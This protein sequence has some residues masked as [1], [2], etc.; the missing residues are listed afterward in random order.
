MSGKR[1]AR[2]VVSVCVAVATLSI[3]CTSGST[4]S[5]PTDPSTADAADADSSE[6][7][8][9]GSDADAAPSCALPRSF[10]SPDC[11]ACVAAKC[12]NEVTACQANETCKALMQCAYDCLL[13]EADAGGCLEGCHATY[14][15][16]RA[17]WDSFEACTYTNQP[18]DGCIL[19][20]TNK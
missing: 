20:C 6:P 8:D 1:A 9:A 2:S 17:L 3:A 5:P 13:L 14:P 11:N 7:M 15:A 4:N 18:E 19:Y 16:A 12:C 10:G